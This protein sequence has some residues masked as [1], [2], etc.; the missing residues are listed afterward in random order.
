MTREELLELLHNNDCEVTFTKVDGTERVM[1]CTLREAALPPRAVNE[2]KLTKATNDNLI[3]VFC[4]DRKEWRSFRVANVT[5]VKII[6]A[7]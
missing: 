4:L 7:N 6:N 5:D 2:T 1:P 3:S